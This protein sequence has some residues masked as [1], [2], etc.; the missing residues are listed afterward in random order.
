[1]KISNTCFNLLLELG[2]ISILQILRISSIHKSK[3]SEYFKLFQIITSNS[4]HL[5]CD[6]NASHYLK[7]ILDSIFCG[8]GG[9]FVNEIVWCYEIGGRIYKKSFGRRHDVI[10][11]Y[12]K[13]KNHTFNW[14]NIFQEWTEKGKAKFRYEDEKCQYRLMGKFIKYSP[15]KGH[16]DVN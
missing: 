13:G 7:I 1:M 6:P 9:D 10:L 2:L 3:D 15:I 4:F 5:H 8:N 11:F 16:R 14:E 12:V